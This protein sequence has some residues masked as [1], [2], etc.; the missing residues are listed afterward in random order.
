MTTS[1]CADPCSR[2]AYLYVPPGAH[3]APAALAEP[4]DGVL[5]FAGEP[6]TGENTVEGGYV[7][8]YDVTDQLITGF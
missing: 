2:G 7:N 1:A 3:D 5:Y 6:T 4:V 8:G